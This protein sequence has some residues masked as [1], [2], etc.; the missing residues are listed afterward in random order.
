MRAAW[1]VYYRADAM[2]WQQDSV[3]VAEH[4]LRLDN[5]F[6]G[7]NHASGGE[8]RLP[9]NAKVAPAM[10]MPVHV[11]ALDVQDGDIGLNGLDMQEPGPGRLN[12]WIAT[13]DVG[14]QERARGQVWNPH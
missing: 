8:A 4:K 10:R 1:R 5:L 6:G 2:R 3:R 12:A 7:D 11:C 13:G 14:A 9:G